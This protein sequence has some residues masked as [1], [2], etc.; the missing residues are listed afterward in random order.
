MNYYYGR[1]EDCESRLPREVRVYDLLD[2]LGIEYG[3][4]DHSPAEN[5][6]D[7]V[8]IDEALGAVMCKN[9]FLCKLLQFQL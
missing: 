7:C 5:M 9:L 4:V 8:A 1:P 6:E 3:R 2:S